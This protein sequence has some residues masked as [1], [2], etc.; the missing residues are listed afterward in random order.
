MSS[1]SQRGPFARLLVACTSSDVALHVHCGFLNEKVEV[2]GTFQKSQWVFCWI[3]K[4]QTKLVGG[5][6]PFEKY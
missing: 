6:D 1:Q 2:N 3:Q 4:T 5:F